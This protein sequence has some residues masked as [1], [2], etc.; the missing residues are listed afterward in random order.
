MA[1]EWHA[2]SASATPWNGS[3]ESPLTPAQRLFI[4]AHRKAYERLHPSISG[5]TEFLNGYERDACPLRR[6]SSCMLIVPS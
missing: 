1:E 3:D 4:G 6:S 2:P 5:D